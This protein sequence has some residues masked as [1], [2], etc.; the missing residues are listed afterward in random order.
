M[1]NEGSLSDKEKEDAL[2]DGVTP[3]EEEF[4]FSK[5]HFNS[6]VIEDDSK[7][8]NSEYNNIL[9]QLQNK[10]LQEKEEILFWL[11]QP[12]N[13]QLLIHHISNS[14]DIDNLIAL[15]AAYW[16]AGINN[17]NDLSV[18]IPFLLSDNFNLMMEAYSAIMC[19]NRPFSHE[20]TMNAVT[21]IKERYDLLPAAHLPLVDEVLDVLNNELT[22]EELF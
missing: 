16:E 19:L 18:F 17:S 7:L 3:L 1:T 9:S 4:L 20:E 13:K 6:T 15:I 2:N 10:T 21:L 14:N 5:K 11:K 12:G 8:Q 22:D